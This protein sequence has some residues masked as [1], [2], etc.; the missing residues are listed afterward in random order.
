MRQRALHLASYAKIN[1]FL[2]ILARRPDGY[3]TIE[4][5]F[6]TITLHDDIQL[7]PRS[8][9]TVRI[10]CTHPQVPVD[11]RNLC[12][13]AARLLQQAT[14]CGQGVDITIIKRI[15]V[16]AGL[17]GGSSNAAIT[18]LGLNRLWETGLE[19]AQLV[20]LA[21]QL[22][23]DI[24]FFLKGGTAFATG[25][26]EVITW[27]PDWR[28]AWVVVV[29]PGFPISTAWAYKNLNLGLTKRKKRFKIIRLQHNCDFSCTEKYGND[30]E[31]LVFEKYP[32]LQACRE[33]L[34]GLGARTALLSGSGSSLYGVFPSRATALSAAAVLGRE[35]PEAG[36]FPARFTGAYGGQ[37]R[38][39]H[40]E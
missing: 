18:L 21:G 7:T 35:Q 33:R 10:S 3:H 14:G 39:I 24:P 28:G 34:A 31:P 27:L 4:T 1:L 38:S 5:L 25:R 2:R 40:T 20:P 13:R 37:G 23:S 32:A 30:F 11:E 16:G 12:H 26:G 8:D 19:F 36:I 29:Y 9:R 6:Q 22:G 17:G 15:P